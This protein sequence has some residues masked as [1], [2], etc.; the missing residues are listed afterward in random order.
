MNAGL[1]NRGD[2]TMHRKKMALFYLVWVRLMNWIQFVGAV[3]PN[4][5]T[6]ECPAAAP[7]NTAGLPPSTRG[8]LRSPIDL[9]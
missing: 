7:E 5:P 2:V 9:S 1:D 3:R 4:T 6:C 8:H